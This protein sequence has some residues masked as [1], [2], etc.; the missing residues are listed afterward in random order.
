MGEKEKDILGPTI[1]VEDLEEEKREM[2]R[3][4]RIRSTIFDGLFTCDIE[5]DKVSSDIRERINDIVDKIYLDSLYVEIQ[6]VSRISEKFDVRKENLIQL[7]D[8]VAS[9]II[10]SLSEAGFSINN[11]ED[12][13][14]LVEVAI[15]DYKKT[16]EK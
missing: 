3:K 16:F 13:T 1:P 15:S 2:V 8:V 10:L 7:T 9:L 5:H 14:N 6:E 11:Q 4:G 12:I